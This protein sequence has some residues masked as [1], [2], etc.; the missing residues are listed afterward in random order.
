MTILICGASG[1]VGIELCK[2]LDIKKIKYYGTY[3]KNKLN[4]DNMFK[5][6][7]FD[8]NDIENFLLNK[9]ISI[10]IYLIAE[11]L[12]D[13]CEKEWDLRKK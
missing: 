2:L 8:I 12:P 3:N 4:E 13:V 1:I 6:N 10:C 7:F 11:R 9:Q 5:L